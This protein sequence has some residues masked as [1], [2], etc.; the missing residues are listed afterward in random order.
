MIG[1]TISHYRIVEKLGGG[2]MGVVYKAEDTELGRFVAL[3]FLPEDVAQDLQA[4]ERFRREARAASALNHPN[5]CTIYEIGKHDGR[6]FIAMEFLDGVTLRHRIAGRPLETD[7][8]LRIATDIADALDAAHAKGIIHRDI[9]PANIFV[10]QRGHAKILDFGLAKLGA[11]GRMAAGA[12]PDSGLPTLT[13]DEPEHLTSPGAAVGTVAY[14]SPEQVRGEVLDTRTDLFSF[15]AVLYEM[16]TGRP[17]FPGNTSGVI[18]HAILERAPTPAARV[19]PDLSPKLGEIISKAL[20]KDR[21]VRY[22]HASDLRADLKRLGRD[23]DT[24]RVAAQSGTAKIV[25]AALAPLSWRRKLAV[26]ITGLVGLLILSAAY[27]F[28]PRRGPATHSVAV[29][30]FANQGANPDMEYLSDGITDGIINSLAQLPQLRVMAHTTVFRYKGKQDDPQKAGRELQV[31][32]VLVGR[33]Q[34]RGDS[35]NVE[36]ELVDVSNGSQLW[37]GQFHRRLADLVGIQEEISREIS[38]NLR[39]KLSG[40]EKQRLTK[41]YTENPEAYQSYLK[42]HYYFLKAGAE[43][44]FKARENFQQ[45]IDKDPGFAMAYAELAGTYVYTPGFSE[46]EAM[47]KAR[48]LASKALDIDDSLGEAHLAMAWVNAWYDW[49]WVA[50]GKQFERAVTLS[51]ASPLAH[52]EYANY[53]SVLGRSDEAVAEGKRAVELD[54]VTPLYSSL[55]GQ[56]LYAARRFDEAIEEERKALEM[57]SSRHASLALGITYAAKGMYRE[58]LLEFQKFPPAGRNLYAAFALARLGERSEALRIIEERRAASKQT[59]VP[60][61]SFAVAYLGLRDKEQVFAFL[62]KACDER[63]ILLTTL[64]VDPLWDPLRSDPHFAHLVRRVGLPP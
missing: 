51:P 33:V 36:T 55:L 42:A 6:S 49:D 35:L 16:A 40:E 2:G 47:P 53:L 22:Q 10:T 29:L 28:L 3:K 41:H 39:L 59:P 4:L 64:K 25:Q 23:T 57:D 52:A 21:E 48:T 63:D 56:Q 37:G 58:A 1:Q 38:E 8:L 30:P 62:Q 44:T 32:A 20:E 54:P 17:A 50:A 15:G 31:G 19:N 60:A 12:T 9:K 45:A 11:P 27:F 43:E 14:M 46:K 5:I 34:Q 26:A 7:V 18:S 24:A 61:S 13:T